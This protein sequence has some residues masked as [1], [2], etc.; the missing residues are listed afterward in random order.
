MAHPRAPFPFLDLRAWLLGSRGLSV[1]YTEQILRALR[2]LQDLGLELEDLVIAPGA[3]LQAADLVLAGVRAAGSLHSLRRFQKA[4]NLVARHQVAR[5]RPEFKIA[6]WDLQPEVAAAVRPYDVDLVEELLTAPAAT[7]LELRDLAA[8]HVLFWTRLRKCEVWALKVED[9]DV[10]ARTWEL[11]R[12]AKSHSAVTK[13]LA[14]PLVDE[15]GPLLQY[16]R[17]RRRRAPSAGATWVRNDG[18]PMTL[19]GFSN[20]TH[21]L[22]V[23]GHDVNFHRWRHTGLTFLD[24]HGVPLQAIQR[25]ANHADPRTTLRY[26]H[27]NPSK[28]ARQLAGA[29]VPGMT[30]HPLA[31][32]S[33]TQWEPLMV[34]LHVSVRESP[35]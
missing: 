21:R 1:T 31:A 24:D 11:R 35:G 5:G 17:A 25:E 22:R 19:A 2:Q 9:L 33:R 6:T 12:P 10:Q 3:A 29:G 13:L 26:V 4:L 28:H 23:K 34:A 27:G 30:D 8:L 16:L 15:H 7:F 18:E 14:S 32:D 20:L